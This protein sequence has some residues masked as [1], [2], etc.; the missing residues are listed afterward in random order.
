[1]NNET[2]NKMEKIYIINT[3]FQKE[4]GTILSHD[5]KSVVVELENKNNGDK[6]T[7]VFSKKTGKAHGCN[8]KILW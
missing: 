8:L 3:T 6:F 1:M 7:R 5:K 2:K 4:Y